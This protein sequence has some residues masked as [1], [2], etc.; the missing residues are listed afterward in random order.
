M[1]RATFDELLA[2]RLQL[3][4]TVLGTKAGE[5]ASEGDRLHNFKAAA[6]LLCDTSAGALTGMLVKHWVSVMDMV[7]AHDLGATFSAEK[8]DE[9][10][11]DIINYLILLEA[12]FAEARGGYA[13]H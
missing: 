4:R 3:T 9:K 8:V 10:I 6:T 1:T 5:Y 7:E 11:G 12:V 2:R 13:T